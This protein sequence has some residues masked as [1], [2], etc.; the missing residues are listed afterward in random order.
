V[1]LFFTLTGEYLNPEVLVDYLNSRFAGGELSL[2]NVSPLKKRGSVYRA[3]FGMETEERFTQPISASACSGLLGIFGISSHS[4]VGEVFYERESD[5]GDSDNV[6]EVLTLNLRR[7]LKT[8]SGKI[9]RCRVI[10]ASR[11][12][13]GM[14]ERGCGREVKDRIKRPGWFSR[15][16]DL[17]DVLP[18]DAFH[19]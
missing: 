9:P 10:V 17:G 16:S 13:Y 2:D 12:C 19:N 7:P 11:C 15:E 1:I 8:K 14:L 4:V 5:M 3:V 6:R 18:N